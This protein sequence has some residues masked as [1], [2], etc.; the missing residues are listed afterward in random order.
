MGVAPVIQRTTKLPTT[1][2]VYNDPPHEG[3]KQVRRAS[4]YIVH[5]SLLT[6]RQF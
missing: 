6:I 2:I 1:L 5:V 3:Y 4:M